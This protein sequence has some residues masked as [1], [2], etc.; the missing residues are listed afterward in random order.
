MPLETALGGIAIAE[1]LFAAT[2][3]GSTQWI[4]DTDS[5]DATEA[6]THI[7]YDTLPPPEDRDTYSPEEWID[8]RPFAIISTRPF[9][10]GYIWKRDAAE[11]WSDSGQLEVQFEYNTPDEMVADDQSLMRWFKNKLGNMLRPDTTVSGQGSYVGMTDLAHDP[12][13]LAMNEI[14][15]FGTPADP[16]VCRINQKLI[17]TYGDCV[18]ARFLVSWGVAQ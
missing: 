1:H 6:L 13:Y 7:Y 12:G 10:G 5:A 4:A 15:F 16:A 17:Q 11:G 2:L 3:A 9:S 18:A 8:L 14:G